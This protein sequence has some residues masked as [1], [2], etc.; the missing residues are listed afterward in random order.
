[1]LSFTESNYISLEFLP[2][3]FT[4]P[5]YRLMFSRSKRR[6]ELS[7]PSAPQAREDHIPRIV[8]SEEG[9]LLHAT[10]AFRA[11]A[12]LRMESQDL[13][14]LGPDIIKVMHQGEA[15]HDF[16]TLPTGIYAV[17]LPRSGRSVRFRFEWM[18]G[19]D[20][21]RYLVGALAPVREDQP[22]LH[23]GPSFEPF[24]NISRDMM[25]L[26]EENG[27]VLKFNMACEKILGWGPQTFQ[28]KSFFDFS[29]TNMQQYLSSPILT[30]GQEFLMKNAAG[31]DLR[32]E[33]R[34]LRQGE[35]YYALG[36]DVG[37]LKAQEKALIRR[38][39]QLEE[40]ESIARMGHWNWTI[41]REIMDWSA[42]L[43]RI[44]GLSPDQFSPGFHSLSACV[45]KSD[46]DRVNKAFQRA[47]IEANDYDMDFRILRP[48]GEI[49]FIRCEG[50]CA[51][52]EEGEVTALYGIMQDMTERIAHEQ[53]LREAKNAAERAYAAK[54][55][56]LANMSHELR[57][58]L[59]AIIG[60]S[61]MMQRQLLGPIGTEKYLEY[62]NGI[63]E[64]GEHLLDLISDIL[65]MSK[66]E[67]GKYELD[68]EEVPLAKTVGLAT[69]MMEG[70]AL[71]ASVR[72][73]PA[74]EI[75]PSLTLVADR[76]AVMQII[77]NLLSN[78][79]KFS[80]EGGEVKILCEERVDSVVLKVID[81]GIGIPPNKL[82][83]IT[84]PFEQASSSYTRDHQGSGLG[85][86]IT[87]ELVEMHGGGLT[88]DSTLG[89]GTIVS[90]RLPFDAQ[91]V[92]ARTQQR[93]RS[94]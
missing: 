35:L 85:L 60:F 21:R 17:E 63:R 43:Y 64:S 15:H 81:T 4:S 53:A 72:I 26:M 67:A 58:P 70:R 27:R 77:L 22:L 94:A 13:P 51:K 45:H 28:D 12:A 83:T 69:H 86:A 31:D 36:R 88:I 47:V 41:G 23:E 19:A 93:A 74:R 38:E 42:E 10:A 29:P 82:A 65:D 90:V 44:F 46:L 80:K 18:N 56:F 40:A 32:V 6:K 7:A 78:A 49:R 25:F 75:P 30:L 14:S 66:I 62:I 57:T 9:N 24:M 68:L 91:R 84:R 71:E 54:S 2:V 16:K 50:R 76:R 92:P 87:K 73:V 8:I 37:A 34:F 33:W 11:L 59:N 5:P 1:M 61:E 52:N 48:D 79:I 89:E 39:K 20:R 55:Q 3:S